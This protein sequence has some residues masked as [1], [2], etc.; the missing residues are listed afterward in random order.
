MNTVKRERETRNKDVTYEKAF[1][2]IVEF[3]N[4]DKDKAMKWY[5]TRNP[6]LGNIAPF[7]MIKQGRGRKLVQFIEVSIAENYL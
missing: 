1:N 2:L 3:F 7:E 5:M 4:D 6:L